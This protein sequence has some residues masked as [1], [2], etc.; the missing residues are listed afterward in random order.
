MFIY[1]S[2]ILSSCVHVTPGVAGEILHLRHPKGGLH[3]V[4]RHS[5]ALRLFQ[6]GFA[7]GDGHLPGLN[8]LRSLGSGS[9]YIT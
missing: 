9:D 7:H 2:F 8:G 6:E 4:A 3:G 1:R 5:E